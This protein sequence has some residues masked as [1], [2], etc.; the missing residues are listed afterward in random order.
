MKTT[1]NIAA[2][3]LCAGK[4]KRMN[5]PN[6]AKV[7]AT[8]G[9]KPLIEH[10][11]R[12]LAPLEPSRTVLVVGHHRESVMEFVRS[13]QYSNTEFAIQAE[14]LGTGHA[15]AQCE[16][17]LRDFDGGVLILAGDVP[18][19]SSETLRRFIEKHR[20]TRSDISVLSTFAPSP[21]GYGRIVRAA[22]G[23]FERITE[24]KDADEE[25]RKINEINTGIYL[26][27]S[28]LLFKS[29]K[30][31]KNNNAQNEYYL[32][33]IIQ[34]EKENNSAVSAFALAQFDE[35]QGVNSVEDLKRAEDSYLSQINQK[36]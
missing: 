11:L 21:T 23:A 1:E 14:Q 29:L 33:D 10:V 7:M 18:L 6:L 24:D 9:G 8:I 3:I 31:V 12:S 34:I 27:S 22:D 19:L 15:V 2:V 30:S 16:D 4:G 13:L 35:V 20:E 25:T 36:R 28:G 5:N 26:V 17:M 32:T